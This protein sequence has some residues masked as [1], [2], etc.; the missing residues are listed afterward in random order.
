[1]TPRQSGTRRHLVELQSITGRV[2]AGDG[3]TDTWATYATAWASVLPADAAAVARVS[4][5]TIESPITHVVETDYRAAIKPQHRV[6][7][8]SA[9]ALYITGIANLEERDITHVLLCEER[10]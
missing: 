9:R 5:N 7:L 10:Q 1:V 8:K 3:Y 4:A 2:P 6:W